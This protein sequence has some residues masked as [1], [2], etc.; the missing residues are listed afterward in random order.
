M[1]RLK[2]WASNPDRVLNTLS[3]FMVGVSFGLFVAGYLK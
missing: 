1:K 3:I 2:E